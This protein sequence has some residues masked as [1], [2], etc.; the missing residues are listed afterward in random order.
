[1]F[2]P[3]RVK[4]IEKN[5]KVLEIGPG[6]TPHPRSDVFLELKYESIEERIAQSGNVGVIQ[7]VKPIVYYD[8]KEFPFDDN[9]F[10][11]V[12]CSHVLEHVYEPEKMVA[13]LTRV[14]RKGYIEFP[15]IYYEF[16]WNIPEH[17][18]ILFW[19]KEKIYYLSK[20]ELH[21]N[22]FK[23]I[24]DFY[25]N[26]MPPNLSNFVDIG[27]KYIMQGFEWENKINIEKAENLSYVTYHDFDKMTLES[28]DTTNFFLKNCL[29]HLKPMILGLKTG[30]NKS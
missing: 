17:V 20:E 7:T 5:D 1:M 30:N 3:E 8:G 19:N 29:N 14:S 2:F 26:V 22:N 27:K 13:E 16:I 15:T 23:P 6:A 25:Y 12:I 24:S 18:M 4:S 28:V 21:F 11:Y 10:D 9:E